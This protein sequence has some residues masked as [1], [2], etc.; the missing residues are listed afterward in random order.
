MEALDNFAMSGRVH[1]VLLCRHFRKPE[2]ATA[3]MD[4]SV[5]PASGLY[6]RVAVVL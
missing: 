5:C 4:C 2:A 1:N 3:D 6:V